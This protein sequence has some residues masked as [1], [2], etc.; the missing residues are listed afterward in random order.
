LQKRFEKGE[1]DST[2]NSFDTY[3]SFLASHPCPPFRLAGLTPISKSLSDR[4]NPK[5]EIH[6]VRNCTV[7]EH[8][9]A[10]GEARTWTGQKHHGNL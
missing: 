1:Q 6:P 5:L 10:G 2:F 9:N 3:F 7:Y 8:I 4:D